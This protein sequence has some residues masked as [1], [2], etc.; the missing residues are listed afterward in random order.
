MQIRQGNPK[1]PLFRPKDI[2]NGVKQLLSVDTKDSL[3]LSCKRPAV[4][5]C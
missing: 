2:E 3:W 5:I 4:C 1:N